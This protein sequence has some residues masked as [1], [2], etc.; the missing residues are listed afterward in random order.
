MKLGVWQVLPENLLN[1]SNKTDREYLDHVLNDGQYIILYNHGNAGH[2]V[3]PH[4]V[5]LYSVLRKHFHVI[6]FDYRS[7]SLRNRSYHKLLTEH[8]L[9][10]LW[11]FR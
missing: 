2:R 11:R 1:G 7:K 4:R 3:S 9:R 10:R 6:A 8:L 5:E